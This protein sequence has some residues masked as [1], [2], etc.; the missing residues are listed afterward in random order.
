MLG[1]EIGAGLEN[2][3][4]EYGRGVLEARRFYGVEMQDISETLDFLLWK[5]IFEL[6]EAAASVVTRNH[7]R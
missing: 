5:G 4:A 1:G 6:H 7:G 2:R 3:V